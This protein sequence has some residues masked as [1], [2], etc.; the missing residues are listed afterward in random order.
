MGKDTLQARKDLQSPSVS[1]REAAAK[2]LVE[3]QL[4]MC[5]V[6]G[7]GFDYDVR[8]GHELNRA[9]VAARVA[10]LKD[11]VLPKRDEA[12][13]ASAL[14]VELANTFRFAH[15]A[16]VELDA[17]Q[18]ALRIVVHARPDEPDAPTVTH[19][20]LADVGLAGSPEALQWW[21]CEEVNRMI[22]LYNGT[23]EDQALYQKEYEAAYCDVFGDEMETVVQEEEA[24]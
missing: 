8:A 15:L 9:R 11:V 5:D 7:R 6:F 14:I 16:R 17:R 2:V 18:A 20:A 3:D 19:R 1:V 23:E 13:V 24:Q 21:V 10:R 12:G 4:N 22:S